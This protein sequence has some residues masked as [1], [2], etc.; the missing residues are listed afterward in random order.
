MEVID[1]SELPQFLGGTCTCADGGG[2]LRSD[3]GPWKDPAI[4]KSVLKG[5]AIFEKNKL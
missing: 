1:S 2:C 3:K 4:M 5:E